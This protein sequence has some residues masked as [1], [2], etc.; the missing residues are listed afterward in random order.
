MILAISF[1]LLTVFGA[2]IG[3]TETFVMGILGVFGTF[4]TQWIKNYADLNGNKALTLTTVVS[5]ALAVLGALASDAFL[6]DT[7]ALT[8]TS[9]VNGAFVV[10]GVAT[11]AY[12]Y[13]LSKDASTPL[14]T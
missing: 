1:M 12:K 7:G 10:F 8:I 13:L 11:L 14:T 4:I 6:D 3:G 5:I 9:V 2:V